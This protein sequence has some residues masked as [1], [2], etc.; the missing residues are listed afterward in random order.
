M[1]LWNDENNGSVNIL[2]DS[3]A[4]GHYFDDD[5]ILRLRDKLDVTMFWMCRAKSQSLVDNWT[6]L[7]RNCSV[8]S[9]STVIVSHSRCG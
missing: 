5:I 3:G 1:G 6:A 8:A 4:S 7:R 9:S 2:V